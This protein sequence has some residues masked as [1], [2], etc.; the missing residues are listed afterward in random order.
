MVIAL[1][2]RLF[3]AY[4]QQKLQRHAGYQ[5]STLGALNV[6]VYEGAATIGELK[7]HGD[8]GLGTFEGLEGEMVALNGDFFQIETD[9]VP[10]RVNKEARTPFASVVSFSR[11]KTL[12]TSG[13]MTYAGL[14]EAIDRQLKTRNL[15]Q[16]IRIYGVFPFLRVRSVPRQVL[17]YPPLAKVVKEQQKVFELHNVRG[18]LVGFRMPQYMSSLNVMGY[19]FHFIASDFKTGGHLLD[20]QFLNAVVET[21]TVRDWQLGLPETASFAAATLP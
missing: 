3:P 10:I 19:H 5:V 13:L 21:Q 20:G 15:P 16:A 1:S 12:R 14:Q 7:E 11:E 9:G 18:T 2:I 17:P 4:A 8:F 6:G